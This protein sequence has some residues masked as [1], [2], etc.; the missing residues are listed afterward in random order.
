MKTVVLIT[1]GEI[2]KFFRSGAVLL[3]GQGNA[4]QGVHPLP[5]TLAGPPRPVEEAQLAT[6]LPL[7]K[8]PS[9]SCR[10]STDTGAPLLEG[11][12]VTGRGRRKRRV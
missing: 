8:S 4:H 12:E 9:G 6:C 2:I 10:D 1:F 7:A 3:L 11:G 5:Q